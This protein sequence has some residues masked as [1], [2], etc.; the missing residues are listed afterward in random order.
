MYNYKFYDK[1]HKTIENG[2][3]IDPVDLDEL[4]KSLNIVL[5]NKDEPG[6]VGAAYNVECILNQYVRNIMHTCGIPVTED[7][8]LVKLAYHADE[9][10]P[11]CEGEWH[12]EQHSIS[13]YPHSYNAAVTLLVTAHETM[14][15]LS[16]LIIDSGYPKYLMNGSGHHP[17]YDCFLH[18]MDRYFGSSYDR[19]AVDM[20]NVDR[21]VRSD[22]FFQPQ[23]I[24]ALLCDTVFYQ[25]PDQMQTYMAN[26]TEWQANLF[27]ARITAAAI[28]DT[29]LRD[30]DKQTFKYYLAHLQKQL[31]TDIS[32]KFKG[33]KKTIKEFDKAYKARVKTL[34]KLIKRQRNAP[35]KLFMRQELTELSDAYATQRAAFLAL[36]N[37]QALA[38]MQNLCRAQ[39]DDI[40]QGFAPTTREELSAQEQLEQMAQKSNLSIID[41]QDISQL[42]LKRAIRTTFSNYQDMAYY[43]KTYITKLDDDA[44]SNIFIDMSDRTIIINNGKSVLEQLQPAALQEEV[45]HEAQ[46]GRYSELQDEPDD[47]EEPEH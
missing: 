38:E 19:D 25:G 16:H 4:Q 41:G 8:N 24:Q 6:K 2:G 32:D 27:A 23:T 1:M 11:L 36:P 5:Q 12:Q 40:V 28:G 22:P 43:V 39:L 45:T 9:A 33:V 15:C 44:R 30:V 7:Y 17:T 20:A 46:E 42:K 14:H 35:T 37:M 29:P 21:F 13:I 47:L 31:Q 26:F 34:T 10:S 18:C 3:P